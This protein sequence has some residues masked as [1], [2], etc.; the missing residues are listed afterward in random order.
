MC[1]AAVQA[2]RR[3]WFEL[4]FLEMQVSVSCFQNVELFR[5]GNSVIH[6]INK[7][8]KKYLAFLL[9]IFLL[10]LF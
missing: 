9:C 1:S 10:L 3:M 8:M 7:I 2:G 4:L 5:A 6:N